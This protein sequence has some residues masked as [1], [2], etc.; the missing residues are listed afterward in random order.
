M[1][2]TLQITGLPEHVVA[3]L[4]RRATEQGVTLC[5][6]VGGLLADHVAQ[7]TASETVTELVEASRAAGFPISPED[8][9]AAVHDARR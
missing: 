5:E 3:T 7:R 4:D 1:S 9:W 6:Y 2:S 8:A